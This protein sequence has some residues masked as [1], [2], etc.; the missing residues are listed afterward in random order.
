MWCNAYFYSISLSVFLK[1]V[2]TFAAA[3]TM[4]SRRSSTASSSHAAALVIGLPR[5]QRR[6]TN[7]IFS[8]AAPSTRNCLPENV[9]N[10]QSFSRLYLNLKTHFF[11]HGSESSRERK[12]HGAKVPW[13]SSRERKFQGAKVPWNFRSRERKFQEAKVPGSESSTLWNFLSWERKF[14]WAKV[15]AYLVPY[16]LS[17][18]VV[19]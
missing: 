18:P 9:C 3:M 17:C 6:L 8:V 14:L 19:F 2:Y 16:R 15:P 5:T 10:C 12:F 4:S 11:A 7:R 13:K 1:S